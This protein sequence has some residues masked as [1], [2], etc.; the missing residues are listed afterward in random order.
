M[1]FVPPSPSHQP[2]R[3]SL[4]MMESDLTPQ[5]ALESP[6]CS[7]VHIAT[8]A[9]AADPVTVSITSPPHTLEL[10]NPISVAMVCAR[11]ALGGLGDRLG[12]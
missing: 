9:E 12:M 10:P 3:P 11:L 2:R 8:S 7:D 1:L 4:L 5:Q 6:L